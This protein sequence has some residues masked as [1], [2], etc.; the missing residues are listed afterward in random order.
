VVTGITPIHT[1]TPVIIGV[2][3]GTTVNLFSRSGAWRAGDGILK[4]DKSMRTILLGLC[5][6]ALLAGLTQKT[7]AQTVTMTLGPAAVDAD[8]VWSDEYQCWLWSGPEFQ[9]DYQGHSFFKEHF[10]N[11]QFFNFFENT[12]ASLWLPIPNIQL[13][14]I[15]GESSVPAP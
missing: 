14:A 10:L 1:G 6:L 15:A 2:D 3:V 9:G 5:A 13:N 8:W 11:H 7:A 4:L 12:P